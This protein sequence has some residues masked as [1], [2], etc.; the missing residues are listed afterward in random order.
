MEAGRLSLSLSYDTPVNDVNRVILTPISCSKAV[1]SLVIYI[2][3]VS[4]VF[5]IIALISGSNISTLKMQCGKNE[6]VHGK[7]KCA[8]K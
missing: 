8:L 6:C 5:N 7:C 4:C 3:A 1:F 2:V